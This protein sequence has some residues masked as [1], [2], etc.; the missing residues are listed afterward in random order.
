MRFYTNRH[1]FYC[2]ILYRTLLQR[3]LQETLTR[4]THRV[5]SLERA[6]KPEGA[7]DE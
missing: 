4:L 6:T 7:G 2:G 5:L 1:A 3:I